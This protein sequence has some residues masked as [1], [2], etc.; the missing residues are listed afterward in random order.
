MIEG[1]GTAELQSHPELPESEFEWEDLLLRLEVM[2]RALRVEM[3][4]VNE[5]DVQPILAELAGREALVQRLLE[6]ASGIVSGASADSP[7]VGAAGSD[8]ARIPSLGGESFV[9][10]DATATYQHGG[11]PA[12]GA[13]VDRFVRLRARNFAMLQRRGI[14]VWKWTIRSEPAAGATVFQLLSLLVGGDV[15]IL[16]RLRQARVV[17]PGSC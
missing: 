9:S 10:H 13:A 16:G 5:D 7:S 15:E 14:E 4:N 8:E 11:E 12:A 6:E 3:E 2:S 1:I 17:L